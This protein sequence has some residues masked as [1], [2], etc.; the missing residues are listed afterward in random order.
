MSLKEMESRNTRAR[1][2]SKIS[3]FRKCTTILTTPRDC[4]PQRG[5]TQ[6]INRVL[7][8]KLV[9]A[10]VGAAVTGAKELPGKSNYFIGKDPSKW[11]TNVP[12]YAQVKYAAVYPGVGS[13]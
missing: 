13:D 8:M 12:N 5:S 4:Q 3:R 10:N 9:G 1:L 11:R 7:R 2:I 6:R